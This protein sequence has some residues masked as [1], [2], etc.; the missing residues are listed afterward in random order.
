MKHSFK[1]DVKEFFRT[2]YGATIL[3]TTLAFLFSGFGWIIVLAAFVDGGLTMGCIVLIVNLIIHGMLA[4]DRYWG[5][6]LIE[7][8]IFR[9][10]G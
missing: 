2:L 5:T 6:Q 10:V 7:K 3:F 9:F 1:E 8:T 4:A